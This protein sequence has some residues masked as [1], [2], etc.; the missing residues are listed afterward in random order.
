MKRK[1]RREWKSVKHFDEVWRSFELR[2]NRWQISS[3]NFKFLIDQN[4]KSHVNLFV[5]KLSPDLPIP[6][7]FSLLKW[8]CFPI[9]IFIY[10]KHL[11]RKGFIWIKSG[12]L[13]LIFVS[14]WLDVAVKLSW[15]K[16]SAR[17]TIQY[18][19]P[20][21]LSLLFFPKLWCDQ[22]NLQVNK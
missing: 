15:W 10:R 1:R 16:F 9:Q 8:Q 2:L 4:L 18:P 13:T 11:E 17:F 21:S 6:R 20:V 7:V 5:K 12:N 19:L 3:K 22:V 14:I